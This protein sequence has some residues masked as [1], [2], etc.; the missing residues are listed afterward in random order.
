MGE[1]GGEGEENE[2]F[3][4]SLDRAHQYNNAGNT[5]ALAEV[6]PINYSM[7]VVYE[8]NYKK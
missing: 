4:I 8:I 1:G 7:I 3:K 2:K 6:V 5:N